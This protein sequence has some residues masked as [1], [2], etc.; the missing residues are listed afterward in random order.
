MALSWALTLGARELNRRWAVGA[1]RACLAVA[2]LAAA[3]GAAAL[4]LSVWELAPE[5]HV[6]PAVLWALAIWITV[7]AGVGVIMQ[8]Y[9]LAG[10]LF[11][12]LTPVYD[13][14]IWNVS[15]YWH[16][17]VLAALV[18]CAVMGLA[19]GVL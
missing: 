11:G 15:L 13:A 10:S 19:P 16:F 14:D 12:K 5:T 9:C 6:Y 3:G 7:H 18:T 1:A 4:L 2:S 8:L 17:Q